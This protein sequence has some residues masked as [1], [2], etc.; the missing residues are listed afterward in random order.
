[1]ERERI[2]GERG[3]SMEK[4][5]SRLFK[6]VSLFVC[7]LS[8]FLFNLNLHSSVTFGS[9][10]SAFRFASG[11]TFNV[12]IA[13][14][15][16]DVD[17]TLVKDENATFQGN[18]IQFTKGVLESADSEALMTAAFDPEG[19]DSIWLNGDSFL[20]QNRVM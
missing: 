3:K 5:L 2:I 16:L 18:R 4:G 20:M 11:A 9:R 8:F 17:G 19:A 7:V 14:D 13:D 1:M 6:R 15:A 12:G 10:N